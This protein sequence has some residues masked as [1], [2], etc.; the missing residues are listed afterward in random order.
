MDAHFDT[1]ESKENT[2]KFVEFMENTC[3]VRDN[4]VNTVPIK[5]QVTIIKYGRL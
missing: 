4:L 3:P 5:S 1:D 2:E